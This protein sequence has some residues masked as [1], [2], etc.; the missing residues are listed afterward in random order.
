MNLFA[1]YTDGMKDGNVNEKSCYSYIGHSTLYTIA[2]P[3]AKR[4][5]L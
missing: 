5:T 1:Q 3:A 2:N 4:D